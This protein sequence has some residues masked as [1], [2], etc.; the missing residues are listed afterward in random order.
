MYA[1]AEVLIRQELGDGVSLI[2]TAHRMRARF[3]PQT[4]RRQQIQTLDTGRL[5]VALNNETKRDLH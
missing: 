2:S 1:Q 3:G 4:N 5:A